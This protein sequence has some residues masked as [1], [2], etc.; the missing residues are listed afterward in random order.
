MGRRVLAQPVYASAAERNWSVYGKI[1]S[2]ER[3]RMGHAVGDKLVYC[4]EAL[5]LKKKLQT[6]SLP[7]ATSRRWKSGTPTLTPT[8]PTTR[9]TSQSD[10]AVRE[11]QAV[12]EKGRDVW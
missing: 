5:H 10:G 7:R 9:R 2:K 1:K 4:H 8:S 12:R 3:N 6:A 11:R